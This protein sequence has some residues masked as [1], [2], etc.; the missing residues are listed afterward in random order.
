MDEAT[1]I[2]ALGSISTATLHESM[3]KANTL[4]PSIRP[5]WTPLS[6]CGPAFTVR[7]RP[8][9]NLATHW[10]LAVAPRGS[11]LVV[12]HEGENQCGGWGEIAS[13]AA[14]ARGLRGLVTDGAVRDTEACQRLGF[15]IFSQ[16]IAIKG[17]T[18]A[19]AGAVNVPVVCAGALVRP[20][21][22]IVADQDGVVVVPREG[23]AAIVEK[24]RQRDRSEAEIMARLRAGE[25]TV[26]LLALRDKLP[27]LAAT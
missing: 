11:I 1:I 25:L 16:G 9:D 22:Y 6:L 4:W 8:G 10:A 12:T 15:P 27:G 13:V 26:D 24:A 21:D 14:L 5:V 3:G 17:T 19:H 18:K 7:A 2:E 20:G 23:A